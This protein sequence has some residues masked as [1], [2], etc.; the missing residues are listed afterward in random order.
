VEMGVSLSSANHRRLEQVC[1]E[2]HCY[3]Q[4]SGKIRM[5]YPANVQGH[6]LFRLY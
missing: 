1:A 2:G 4:Q 5:A 3:S 6:S